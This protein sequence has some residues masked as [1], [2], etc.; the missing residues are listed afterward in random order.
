[1]LA[2]VLCV[3]VQI[4]NLTDSWTEVDALNLAV[5]ERR[6]EELYPQSPCLKTFIKKEE[7]VYHAVC[8]I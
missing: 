6:C 7:R 8:G 5:A 2:L 4:T 1:M 3:A